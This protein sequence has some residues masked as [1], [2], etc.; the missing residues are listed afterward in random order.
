[1]K[2]FLVTILLV[3]AS[4]LLFFH[5]I[6]SWEDRV[7]DLLAKEMVSKYNL[8]IKLYKKVNQ[9]PFCEMVGS[10]PVCTKNARTIPKEFVRRLTQ[11]PT[12][13]KK[14]TGAF[15]AKKGTL[16]NCE[17]PG[18]DDIKFFCST[19]QKAAKGAGKCSY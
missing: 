10:M 17:F 18:P 19:L 9:Q 4:I 7:V 15:S 2:Y 1:M 11:K 5:H 3:L 16:Y 13:L 14:L 12:F 8:C 6:P